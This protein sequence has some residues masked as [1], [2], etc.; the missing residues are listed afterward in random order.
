[1]T[2]TTTTPTPTPTPAPI[3]TPSSTSFTIGEE[4]ETTATA[5][6]RTSPT[7][8]TQGGQRQWGEQTGLQRKGATGTIV[9][10]PET[11]SGYTW[12]QV[13][14]TSGPDGWVAQNYLAAAT[15]P[16]PTPTTP[17]Q[18]PGP[19]HQQQQQQQNEY[20]SKIFSQALQTVDSLIAELTTLRAS[21]VA[22][23]AGALPGQ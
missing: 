11:G 22:G 19:S 14:F 10:G 1:M 8:S 18:N 15:A 3:T 16:A 21:L 7:S 17:S 13:N 9:A 5:N 6:V 4:V 23:A 2:V 12:W 20:R